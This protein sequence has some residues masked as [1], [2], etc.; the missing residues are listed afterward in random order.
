M[1]NTLDNRRENE[2]A[3]RSFRVAIAAATANDML[4]QIVCGVWDRRQGPMW[5]KIEE[6]FRTPSRREAA[7]DDHQMIFNALVARDPVDAKEQMR[8]H[9]SR[10]I[11]EFGK[12]W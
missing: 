3:D 6:H 10:V 5:E 7:I 1:L 9:I 12:A 11:S 4:A 8:R 2:I